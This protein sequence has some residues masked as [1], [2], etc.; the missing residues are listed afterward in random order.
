TESKAYPAQKEAA[1]S[2]AVAPGGERLF[3]GLFDGTLNALGS[4]GKAI[5]AL[6]PIKPKPPVLAKVEPSALR[7]GATHEIRI[8]GQ[9]LDGATLTAAGIVLKP[10]PGKA[11]TYQAI[12]PATLAPGVVQLTATTEGGK[13]KPVSLT[14]DRFAAVEEKEPNDSRT[15]A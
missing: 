9:H 2:L 13:S 8:T 11:G 3:V 12:V 1:L 5:A 4:D 15:A 6:L 10:V 7:R 14:I